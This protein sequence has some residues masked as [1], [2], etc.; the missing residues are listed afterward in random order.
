MKRFLG[1]LPGVVRGRPAIGDSDLKNMKSVKTEA[2]DRFRMKNKRASYG[3][4][5]EK[6]NFKL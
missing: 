1:A 4:H 3:V 6:N 2:G 5:P